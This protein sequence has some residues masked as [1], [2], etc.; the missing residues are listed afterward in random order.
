L[1]GKGSAELL[2][3]AAEADAESAGEVERTWVELLER[4]PPD[5]PDMGQALEGL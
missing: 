4:H 5:A 2:R 1:G 3:T